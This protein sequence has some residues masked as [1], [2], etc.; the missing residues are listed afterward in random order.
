MKDLNRIILK[1]SYLDIGAINFY[2]KCFN[3][4]VLHNK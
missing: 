1:K 3:T 2:H 4:F